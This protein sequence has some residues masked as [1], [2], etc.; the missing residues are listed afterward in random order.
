MIS[1][2][3]VSSRK[4]QNRRTMLVGLAAFGL[5][6]ML[7]VRSMAL[8]S[9]QAQA[10][11][12]R[13]VNDIT[14]I[15]NSGQSANQMFAQFEQLFAR[16]ADVPRVAQLVLGPPNRSASASQRSAFTQAFQVY[17]ARKYGRR[18]REFI[19]G[20]L[21]VN[22]ARAVKSYHEVSTTALLAG[23]APFEVTFV[24]DDSSGRFIDMLIEG[25]SLIKS[26]RAEIGAMLD[27]RRGDLDRLITDLRSAG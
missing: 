9:A 21:V 1:T 13:V 5:V 2:K 27:Q 4:M 17:M 14:A 22:G 10:Q 12:T 19:G 23:E 16:Y 26:E 7:P 11:I 6:G 3:K 18:F 24:V 15:I 20:K 8:T 25:I